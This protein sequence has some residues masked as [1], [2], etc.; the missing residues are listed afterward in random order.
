MQNRYATALLAAATCFF[1]AAASAHDDRYHEDRHQRQQSDRHRPPWRSAATGPSTRWPRTSSRSEQGADF[2]EPDLVVDQGRRARRPPRERD[3]RHHRRRRASRVRR[4]PARPRRSTA[5]RVTG[6]FTEDFTLA[7]LKT[8]RAKERI[9]ARAAGEHASTTAG[10]RCRPSRRCSTCAAARTR[11][12]AARSAS[13][14]RPSTRRTSA[15]GLPLE[16]PLVRMLQQQRP[17]AQRAPVFIQSFEVANLQRA[18]PRMTG[19]RLA[20]LINSA[21]TPWDFTVAGDPRTY[22]D[23]ATAG[24]PRG[25]RDLRRRGRARART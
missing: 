25:D 24:R 6:W 19:V 13:T 16:E 2:I 3:R 7:E 9:P 1:S 17:P 12:R 22:A 4:P 21:G 23:L 11:A 18:R 8:L 15:V 14:R 5:C 20:Q 10:S